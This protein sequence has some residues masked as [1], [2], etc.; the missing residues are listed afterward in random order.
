MIYLIRYLF[1]PPNKYRA[2]HIYTHIHPG[3]IYGLSSIEDAEEMV[4][5]YAHQLHGHLVVKGKCLGGKEKSR[6]ELV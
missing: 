6:D 5:N 3:E 4:S 1:P 2:A